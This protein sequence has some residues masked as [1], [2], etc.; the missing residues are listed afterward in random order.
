MRVKSGVGAEAAACKLVGVA[1]SRQ[2]AP[3]TLDPSGAPCRAPTIE[4]SRSSR[5][6]NATAAFT[7]APRQSASSAICST[8]SGSQSSGSSP[9]SAALGAFRTMPSRTAV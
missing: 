8:V 4:P 5:S 2:S 6:S 1:I 9:A 7:R 3:A